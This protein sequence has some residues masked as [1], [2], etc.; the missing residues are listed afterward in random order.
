VVLSCPAYEE[1]LAKCEMVD[2]E[3]RRQYQHDR[4]DDEPASEE[5]SSN[6]AMMGIRLPRHVIRTFAAEAER[7]AQ[8]GA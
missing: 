2:P 8:P 6:L 4:A 5:S 7:R 3:I 1:L